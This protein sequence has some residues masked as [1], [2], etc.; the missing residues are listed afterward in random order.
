MQNGEREKIDRGDLLAFTHGGHGR[1]DE[2]SQLS[3][4]AAEASVE[5]VDHPPAHVDGATLGPL[6]EA[7]SACA[8]NGIEPLCQHTFGHGA[9]VRSRQADRSRGSSSCVW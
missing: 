4:R 9:A 8:R 2:R 3:R 1:R 7:T 6:Y 5:H